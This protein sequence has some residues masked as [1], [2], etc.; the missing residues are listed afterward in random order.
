ML[1]GGD[2]R[3]N[4]HGIARILSEKVSLPGVGTHIGN[5][6]IN[7]FQINSWNTIYNDDVVDL[8]APT[9]EYEPIRKFCKFI[10]FH[11]HIFSDILINSLFSSE[12]STTLSGKCKCSPSPSRWHT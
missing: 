6:K 1:L 10:H 5:K 9:Y 2:S 4:F 3:L 12:C 8:Q 11:M 7:D